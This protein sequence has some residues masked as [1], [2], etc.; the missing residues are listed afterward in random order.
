MSWMLSYPV[1]SLFYLFL[2]LS[3]ILLWFPGKW[4]IPSWSIAL[5]LSIIF[6]FFSHQLEWSALVSIM[7]LAFSAY[8][9]QAKQVK[10]LLHF[11][12]VIFVLILGIGLASHQLPGFNNL[13]VLDH[14]YYTRDAL[15]FSLY[16]NFDKTIVGIFI[17]AFGGQ[18]IS[19]KSEW[20]LLLRQLKI[21]APIVILGVLTLAFIFKYVRFE[22]KLPS[23][24]IIWTVTNL[25]LVCTAEEAFFRGFIQKKLSALM[26]KTKYGDYFAIGLTSVLFGFAHYA[27]GIKYVILA[28]AAGVGYGWVYFT[29]KRIEGS[30]LTH[31]SLNCVH[32]LFFT[33]PALASAM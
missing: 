33:Y 3:V 16:L 23:S 9:S 18:L 7:L 2:Y 27:G 5:T 11:L 29:T 26:K 20:L 24:F 17:L 6:G 12:A 14:I 19:Q 32:F 1:V 25:L 13:N 10:H 31:F 8:Y 30:I 15:P 4:K 21:K 28:A 22:F